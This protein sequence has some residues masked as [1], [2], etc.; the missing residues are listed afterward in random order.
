MDYCCYGAAMTCAVLG[1][2]SSVTAVSARLR[3]HD[4]PAE[5]NAVIIMQHPQAISTAV[6]SWTQSG[7]LTSYEP[8]FYGS[9]GTIVVRE[10]GSELWLAN[11][12][13]DA[14]AKLDVSEPPAA[15]RDSA[16][17]FLSHIRSGEPISGMCGPDVSL[18]AQQ[19]LE[20]GLLS[21]TEGCA[22]RLPLPV[23]RLA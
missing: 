21:A 1:L 9:A 5:D 10:M 19:V 17:F 15:M 6:A 16:S 13:N 18:M 23:S 3:K 2:P 4:L 7:H 20:A 12:K 22:V 14:G 11:D 8:M